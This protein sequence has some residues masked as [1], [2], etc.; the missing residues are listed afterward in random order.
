MET[1]EVKAPTL[2]DP[3]PEVVAVE[4]VHAEDLSNLDPP[5]LDETGFSSSMPKAVSG[6]KAKKTKVPKLAEQF[7]ADSA[8]ESETEGGS[9]AAN[10]LSSNVLTIHKQLEALR[11]EASRL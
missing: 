2:S 3:L 8:S 7:F 11:N 6:M 5:E 9:R 10:I 4:D 1:T